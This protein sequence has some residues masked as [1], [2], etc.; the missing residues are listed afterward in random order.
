M[1]YLSFF[2]LLLSI[3][4]GDI[5]LSS[6]LIPFQENFILWHLNYLEKIFSFGV[7]SVCFGIIFL[8]KWLREKK[9]PENLLE[10]CFS[11]FVLFFATYAL[12]ALIGRARPSTLFFELGPYFHPL[13]LSN[14]YFS[15]PSSHSVAAF[16]AAS[17]LS[18]RFPRFKGL[19]YSIAF[20]ISIFRVITLNHFLSDVL[21]GAFLGSVVTK[22][23]LNKKRTRSILVRYG[24]KNP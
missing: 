18:E 20:I 4:S 7:I 21:I 10:V 8:I 6:L 22:D 9:L 3:V 19:F 17:G 23:F 2:L 24:L 15:F 1:K 11:F 12:K 5:I 16:I 14:N 13:T